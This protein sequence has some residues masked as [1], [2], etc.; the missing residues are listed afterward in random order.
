EQGDGGRGAEHGRSGGQ[1]ATA[2][3]GRPGD[4]VAAGGGTAHEVLREGLGKKSGPTGSG[5]ADLLQGRAGGGEAVSK[6]PAVALRADFGT[7][8]RGL[9]LCPQRVN[10]SSD[11]SVRYNSCLVR[12]LYAAAQSDNRHLR[13]GL[14]NQHSLTSSGRGDTP[15]RHDSKP[16]HRRVRPPRGMNKNRETHTHRAFR[17]R[18]AARRLG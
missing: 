18:R 4:V 3:D 16:F 10:D 17:G 1:Q 11:V 5:G 7:R 12:D 14:V 13:S 8:M 15:T 2:T 6:D 9:H